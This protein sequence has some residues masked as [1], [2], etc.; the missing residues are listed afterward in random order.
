[1]WN[2]KI[3]NKIHRVHPLKIIHANFKKKNQN[4]LIIG[5]TEKNPRRGNSS[6]PRD[7]KKSDQRQVQESK[8]RWSKFLIQYIST[9]E[10]KEILQHC[11]WGTSITMPANKI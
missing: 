6:S 2:Q 7:Q 4:G 3:L 8:Q 5:F 11:M 10:A 1:M 9:L